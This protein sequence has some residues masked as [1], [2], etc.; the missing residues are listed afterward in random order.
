MRYAPCDKGLRRLAL[1]ASQPATS[2]SVSDSCF[3][4]GVYFYNF[5][6]DC[7]IQQTGKLVIID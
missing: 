3:E 1:S 4:S 2:E 7:T 5:T 6:I